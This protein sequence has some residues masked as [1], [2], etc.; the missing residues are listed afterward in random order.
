MRDELDTKTEDMFPLE[1]AQAV[2]Q[3]WMRPFADLEQLN[4]AIEDLMR[5]DLFSLE[6]GEP[7]A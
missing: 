7:C 3:A 5:G 1:G 6:G 4:D 2:Y